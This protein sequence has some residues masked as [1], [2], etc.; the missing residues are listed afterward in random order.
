MKKVSLVLSILLAFALFASC[1]TAEEAGPAL[2]AYFTFDDAENLGADASGNGNDL[3]KAINPDGIKAVEGISGGAVYFSGSSGLVA[4]DDS[5]NDFIDVYAQTGRDVT[6][7]F[8]AKIDADNARFGGNSRAVD[9]GINGSDEGFTI[10]VNAN[11]AEDGTVS[12]FS[13]SKVGGSDW[14][15]SAS[16][17][18]NDPEGWHHYVMVYDSEN[19]KVVTFVDG[20][21]IQEVYADSEEK[22]AGSFTFCVGGNWAQWDWYNGGNHDVTMEGFIGAIDELKIYAGAV[23]DVDMFK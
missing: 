3:V 9:C 1:V 21:Q 2:L 15:S 18:E 14:W 19:E 12:V 4:Y 23:Y 6:V 13:I 11:K 5:N 10:L 17:V 7:S 20:I 22:I 8:Y 16:A